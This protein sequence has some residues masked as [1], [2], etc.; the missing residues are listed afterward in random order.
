MISHPSVLPL[1]F[2]LNTLSSHYIAHFVYSA[3]A[4]SWR[5]ISIAAFVRIKCKFL[6]IL[7]FICLFL[8]IFCAVVAAT[9]FQ[10]KFIC[11]AYGPCALRKLE[12]KFDAINAV[13]NKQNRNRIQK[14][15]KRR[16][17]QEQDDDDVNIEASEKKFIH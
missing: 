10:V 14:E 8:K 11:G 4:V 9:K 13:Y 15:R 6:I 3:V 16:R 17:R 2:R 5:V 12:I 1:N 7:L